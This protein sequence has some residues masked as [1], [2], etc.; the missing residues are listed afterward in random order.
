MSKRDFLDYLGNKIGELEEPVGIT[1]SEET[2]A[3][4][5][6]PFAKAP[7]S[8]DQIIHKI[9]E[10]TIKQRKEYA[11]DLIERFKNFNMTSGI[12]IL[13]ALWLQHRMRALSITVYGVNF[14]VDIMNL[15]VSGDVEVACVALQY[16]QVDDMSLPY[17]FFN[18]ARRNWL[19]ADMKSYLGWA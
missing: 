15:V 12:N 18:D 13:Q 10:A 4:K 2:W 14:T 11:D 7:E 16:A 9:L 3:E 19:V 5:L 17:H 6:A 8:N 1:W